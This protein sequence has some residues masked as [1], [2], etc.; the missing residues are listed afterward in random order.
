MTRIV[1]LKLFNEKANNRE[2]LY[3]SGIILSLAVGRR[4]SAIEAWWIASTKF[5]SIKV[6][7][8]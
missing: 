4:V 1:F 3:Q 6:Q 7:L 8:K 5:S 2:N